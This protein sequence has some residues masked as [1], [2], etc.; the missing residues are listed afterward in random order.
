M[1]P[2]KR[3][4]EESIWAMYLT[5][6][7]KTDR[8]LAEDWKGNTDGILIITGLFSATVAAFVIDSYKNLQ[9][10]PNS[11]TIALLSQISAQLAAASNGT[12]LP[13]PSPIVSTFQ[14][15]SSAIRINILWFLSLILSVS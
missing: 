2:K 8:D 1:E 10:D 15:S 12:H 9:P 5:R 11:A 14:P 7:E 13:F 3:A 6:V 4:N